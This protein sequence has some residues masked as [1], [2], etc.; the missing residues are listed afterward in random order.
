MNLEKR[1]YNVKHIKKLIIGQNTIT[2]P[3]AI[4][5]EQKN[6]FNNLYASKQKLDGIADTE[7]KFLENPA[8]PKLT[9]DQK[10]LCDQKLHAYDYGNA[11]KKLAN[12]KSPGSDGLTTN[13]YKFF[14]PDIC[15]L[16]IESYEYTYKDKQLS[17]EQKLAIINLIPKK[18]KDLKFLKNWRPVSLLNTD[19]KILT[20]ALAEK[21]QKVI[22]DIID[23]DQIGYIK[24]RFIGE[25]IRTIFDIKNITEKLD[26]GG[27]IALIDFEKA[28]DSIEWAFLLKCLK[29]F[30][31]GESFISWIK[32]LY[33]D[34][35][36]CVS[37]NGYHSET[38]NLSR[39]VRQGCPI[40]ALLFIIVAEIL[41]INIR[42]NKNIRGL[43]FIRKDIKEEYKIVQ[44]ADDT[45]LFLADIKSVSQSVALFHKF[46]TVS[47]LTI[48]LEKTEV[49]P[50]GRLKKLNIKLPSELKKINLNTGP[51]KTLGIWFSNNDK[52]ILDM[53]FYSRIEKIKTLLQIWSGRHLSLKGKITVLKTLVIPQISFLFSVLFVP[54]YI[55]EDIDKLLL[56]FL[57][58]KKTPKVKRETIIASIEDGG[59]KMP[60]IFEI[61]KTSKIMWIKRLSVEGTTKW[62]KLMLSFLNLEKNQFAQ[63]LCPKMQK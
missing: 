6:Y 45:T 1:N 50:L 25:S 33:T 19:Y 63:F 51:F 3:I 62:K 47:G 15:N 55:L 59:L 57:W 48:N 44:L 43:N 13:F 14:W 5:T 40:S 49:I 26:L 41:A 32:I 9:E 21:L 2:D 60:D 37:N 56:S 16:L 39:S 23:R 35:K 34:I 52:E 38:F 24:G 8:I 27:Y 18:D 30:N 11:L 54:L 36:S 20:K 29:A 22:G 10:K 58:N 53:N 4:L 31:F 61:N 12:N 17:Q 42:S 7:S 28:F 46:E